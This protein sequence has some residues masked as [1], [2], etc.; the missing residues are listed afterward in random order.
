MSDLNRALN[1]MITARDAQIEARDLYNGTN[2]EVFISEAVRRALG[3]STDKFRLNYARIPVTARLSRLTLNALTSPDESTAQLMD[4]VWEANGLGFES[5]EVTESTLVDGETY[6]L[7]WPNEEDSVDI[8]HNA[9]DQMRLFYR[10]DN[11][12]KKH[13]AA[14]RWVQEDGF[15]RVTLYYA[16]RIE[17]YISDKPNSTYQLDDKDFVEF[18]DEA[19]DVWPE[20]N[21]YGEVPVFHFRTKRQYGRPIHADAYGPQRLIDKL[22]ASHAASIETAS[23]PQRYILE[24]MAKNDGVANSNHWAEDIDEETSEGLG[25]GTNN[26]VGGS[27]TVWTLKGVQSV[28]EFSS[29]DPKVFTDPMQVYVTSMST[30][31]NT[32][33]HAFNVGALPS[34]EAL[35]V[36][37]APLVK[38]VQALQRMFG[39][40]WSEVFAF[41]LKVMGVG[42]TP[43]INVEWE[44]AASYNSKDIVETAILKISA[45][46]SVTQALQEIGYTSEQVEEFLATLPVQPVEEI[47]PTL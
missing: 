18:V 47:A 31:T 15:E 38:D 43:Q 24:N 4:Q 5:H 7:V 16:D 44:P 11:P 35:R 14:K 30:V 46:V 32:P 23:F 9:C 34:G 33:L 42:E 13:F 39:A 28:G 27:G 19:G 8:W 45:G 41:A 2:T 6:V 40:T 36:V 12:R 21:P 10:K 3:T 29:A 37:E 25:T 1:S 17:R 26:L 20:P 22:T